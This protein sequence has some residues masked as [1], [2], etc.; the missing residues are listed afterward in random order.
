MDEYSRIVIEQYCRAHC[1]TKKSA[2]LQNLLKLSYS[3]D[4]EPED[5]E[6]LRLS[7]YIAG[8]KDPELRDALEDLDEYLFG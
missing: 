7:Q 8:E 4:C 5:W 1:G 6:A 3:M 2:L